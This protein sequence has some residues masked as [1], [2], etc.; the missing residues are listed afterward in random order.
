VLW[1]EWQHVLQALEEIR[2]DDANSAERQ[3]GE[4]VLLPGLLVRG[5]DP[6]QSVNEALEPPEHARERLAIA[7]EH[8]EHVDAER[9]RD[10]D[11][12]G[13]EDDDLQP[14]GDGHGMISSEFLGADEGVDEV[15]RKGQG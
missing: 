1:V 14:T 5:V 8:T 12:R 7:L 4:R 6:A 11:D 3:Q 15:G 10:S 13:E 2:D 9:L